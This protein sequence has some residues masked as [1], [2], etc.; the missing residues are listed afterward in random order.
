VGSEALTSRFPLGFKNR[1]HVLVIFVLV[2]FSSC[3]L[4]P[5]FCFNSLILNGLS[6]FQVISD[7][8]GRV[9]ILSTKGFDLIPHKLL[10]WDDFCF[11]EKNRCSLHDLNFLEFCWSFGFQT[12]GVFF[13][14]CIFTSLPNFI[15][16]GVDLDGFC[17]SGESFRAA[18]T[19][20]AEVLYRNAEV[21]H[22]NVELPHSNVEL[23]RSCVELLWPEQIWFQVG[24]LSFVSPFCEMF[25]PMGS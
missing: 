17:L 2:F 15:P 16:I 1:V 14:T 10:D 7:D 13:L 3:F 19:D 24:S 4:P 23:P 25:V 22:S 18:G 20:N 12:L 8:Q 5:L 21:L 9:L 6:S 11:G